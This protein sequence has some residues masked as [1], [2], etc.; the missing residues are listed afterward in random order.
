MNMYQVVA[1]SLQNEQLQ[2]HFFLKWSWLELLEKPRDIA[3]KYDKELG[4]PG[5]QQEI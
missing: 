2:D 3:E 1:H 4:L 5:N